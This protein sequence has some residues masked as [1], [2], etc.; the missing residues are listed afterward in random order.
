MLGMEAV[1]MAVFGLVYF[2]RKESGSRKP[3]IFKALATFMPVL[4]ALSFAV[5]V[6]GGTQSFCL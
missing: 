3:L 5:G 6:A 2:F 4:M 1:F